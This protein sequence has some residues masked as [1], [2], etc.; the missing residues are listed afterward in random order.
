MIKTFCLIIVN[1]KVLLGK[2]RLCSEVFS[3]FLKGTLPS[4]RIT[5][6][7]CIDLGLLAGY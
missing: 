3:I 1:D 5:H 2:A 4:F 6:Q 7:I